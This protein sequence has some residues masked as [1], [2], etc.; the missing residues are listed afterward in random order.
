M[1]TLIY[2]LITLFLSSCGSNNFAKRRYMKG[3]YVEKRT[4]VKSQKAKVKNQKYQVVEEKIS[5]KEKSVPKKEIIVSKDDQKNE[6]EIDSKIEEQILVDKVESFEEEIIAENE[7]EYKTIPKRNNY[8]LEEFDRELNQIKIAGFSLLGIGIFLLILFFLSVFLFQFYIWISV[9]I[10][11]PLASGALLSSFILLGKLV[12][13]NKQKRNLDNPSEIK[14]KD[15][16]KTKKG[17]IK[18]I[19]IYIMSF[20]AFTLIV[21]ELVLAMSLLLVSLSFIFSGWGFFLSI[22]SIAQIFKPMF[23]KSSKG[24]RLMAILAFVISFML[25]IAGLLMFLIILL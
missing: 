21:M 22:L 25:M 20:I 10:L 5:R 15:K 13:N 6:K 14:R 11:F 7:I 3:V 16:N 9:Y 1:K 2:I 18:A 8:D 4:H 17:K 23:N 12:Y 19:T 24:E